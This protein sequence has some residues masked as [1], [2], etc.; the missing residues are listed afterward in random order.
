LP[1]KAATIPLAAK[2]AGAMRIAIIQARD[3]FH[4]SALAGSQS[5]NDWRSDDGDVAGRSSS[6]VTFVEL[7]MIIML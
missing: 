2:K 4:A 7:L 1:A 3:R 6:L 5:S